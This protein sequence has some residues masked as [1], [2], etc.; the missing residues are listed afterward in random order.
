MDKTLLLNRF[1]TD[2]KGRQLLADLNERFTT[3]ACT[4][5]GGHE[6]SAP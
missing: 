6:L 3:Q 1:L 2:G 4:G 5:D